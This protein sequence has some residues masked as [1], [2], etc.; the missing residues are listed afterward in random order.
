M[1]FNE[2]VIPDVSANF[3]YQEALARY[4]FAQKYLKPKF[5]V[6]D[7]G[8]GTGY[9]TKLLGEKVPEIIGIDIN[10]EAIN[11]AKKNYPKKANFRIG[12]VELLKF[13]D[14]YF[15]LICSF[16]VIEHLKNPQK[17]YLKEIKRV[18]KKDGK[19]I[20][21]TPNKETRSPESEVS[22]PYHF[23]EYKYSEFKKL[24]KK[25]FS[26]VEIK[27]QFR[28]KRTKKAL[29]S[30]M[31]SQKGRQKIVGFD[32]LNFRKL[33]PKKYKEWI[34]KYVGFFFGRSDQASLNFKNFPI[35][36]QNIKNC[37]YFIAI[38]EK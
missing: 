17:K 13:K 8:C 28:S 9:G 2:R 36:S 11:F 15:N 7:L 32:K 37:E 1:D 4:K 35:H 3:L 5:K 10:K 16:E 23:R 14:N 26:K 24:L 34:W 27:G 25:N 22:S 30:F 20:F 19:V 31:N 18:L 33:I 29:K 38:C 21:S 12:N 6:L